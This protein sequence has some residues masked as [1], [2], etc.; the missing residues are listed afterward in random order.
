MCMRTFSTD[1]EKAESKGWK[2]KGNLQKDPK[3]FDSKNL[4]LKSG[5]LRFYIINLVTSEIS[6]SDL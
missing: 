1:I 2:V 5:F 4:F 6:E 3:R